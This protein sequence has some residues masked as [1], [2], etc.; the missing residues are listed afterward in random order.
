MIKGTCH[1]GAVT[2]AFNE[3]PEWTTAC[4]CSVCRRLGTLWIYSLAANIEIEATDGT[5]AYSYGKKNLAFHSCKTCGCTTH[6]ENV[7]SPSG[8]MAV[9][10]KLADPDV[11]AKIP[12]R[13]FDGADTWQY[14]D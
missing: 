1:C 14:L 4:N 8:K 10:L 11:I 5:I 12:V 2:Y 7:K 9:N 13:Q 3:T 6:W